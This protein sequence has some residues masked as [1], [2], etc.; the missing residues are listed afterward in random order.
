MNYTTPQG[1]RDVL[2]SEAAEREQIV[3][4]V[5]DLFA[6][7]GYAPI[8]T[9]TLESMDVMR[10]GGRI[11]ASPFKFFD[12]QGSLVTMRPDVTL[13]VARM[14]ATRLGDEPGPFRFRYIQRVFR[15]V[16]GQ[17][18][19]DA[20]EKKQIGIEC[21]GESGPEVDAEVVSLFVGAM[22]V[23][24]VGD[25]K[26]SIATVG[27]LRALLEASDA[28]ASWKE[29]ALD[30]FHESNFVM[31]DQ[32]C[33][34]AEAQGITYASAIRRLARVRG[35]RA[36]IDEARGIVATTATLLKK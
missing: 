23:A 30:A 12:A 31:L 1:F 3:R 34:A 4:R 28:P 29:Q 32:L 8:E 22:N 19:A 17:V 16:E 10:E 9:P 18:G 24:G 7:A 15:E 13:Q 21:I 11:P 27:V 5:Q 35:A 33:D 20:R 14:C 25:F 36:A 26:L 2:A 6:Q